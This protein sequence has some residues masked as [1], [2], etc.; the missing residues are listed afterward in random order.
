MFFEDGKAWGRS[1]RLISPNLNGHNVEAMLPIMSKVTR[2]RKR[3]RG[4][5]RMVCVTRALDVS[6]ASCVGAVD[7]L[8]VHQQGHLAVPAETQHV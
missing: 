3:L 6:S 5:V 1:R 8:E 4:R 2:P 7:R